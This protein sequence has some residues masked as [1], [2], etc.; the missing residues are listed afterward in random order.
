VALEPEIAGATKGTR[1][2]SQ[3]FS[4]QPILAFSIELKTPES[5]GRR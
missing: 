4:T 2:I 5:F 1:T 3:I